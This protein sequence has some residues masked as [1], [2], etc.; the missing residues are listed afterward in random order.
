M[1]RIP[2]L[3]PPHGQQCCYVDDG[4]LITGGPGAGTPDYVGPGPWPIQ[5]EEHLRVDVVPFFAC[6]MAGMKADGS[7]LWVDEYYKRRKANTGKDEN[8]KDCPALI[9]YPDDPNL[10]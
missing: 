1:P 4:R 7:G 8:G 3:A 5:L 9:Q 6:Q 10:P 2:K